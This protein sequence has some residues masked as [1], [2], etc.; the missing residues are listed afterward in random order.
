M[1]LAAESTVV[2][3]RNSIVLVFGFS[4]FALASWL[5]RVPSARDGLNAT[6]LQM[7]VLAL[8]ISAGSIGGFYV[9]SRVAS[10]FE[11]QRVIVVALCGSTVGLV[12]AG[13]GASTFG[14]YPLAFAG[15]LLLG[16]SNGTCNVTMNLEGSGIE[17]ALGKPLMPW[18]HASFSIGAAVGAGG[19]ALAAGLGIP[20]ALHLGAA[21]IVMVVVGVA[22]TVRRWPAVGSVPASSEPAVSVPAVPVSAEP[23][24]GTLPLVTR[25]RSAWFERRTILIGVVVLGMSFATGAANDWVALATADGRGASNGVAALTIGVFT[26]AVVVARLSG[27]SLLSRFGRVRTVQGSAIVAVVG[28]LLFIFGGSVATGFIGAAL[29]GLGVALAFPIGMSAA[30]DDHRF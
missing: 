8:G 10:R 1:T 3:W 13:L 6:T 11:P 27:V 9:A 18:F 17:R 29:W 2:A 16:L 15:L 5:S 19:G 28:M 20:V 30:G 25:R 26:V 22:A 7:G 14:S 4:G 21:A 24:N 12:V 23:S